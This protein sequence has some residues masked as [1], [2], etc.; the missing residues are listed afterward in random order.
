MVSVCFESHHTIS[1]WV[2][3]IIIQQLHTSLYNCEYI[4]IQNVRDGSILAVSFICQSCSRVLAHPSEFLLLLLKKAF[5]KSSPYNHLLADLQR[6]GLLLHNS[7]LNFFIF[8]LLTKR[9]AK[10]WWISMKAPFLVDLNTHTR[11]ILLLH[12]P[13]DSLQGEETSSPALQTFIQEQL[14]P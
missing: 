12:A 5:L 13:A 9:T 11:G 7:S 1:A 4:S 6:P 2:I 3:L 10:F 14:P 8:F